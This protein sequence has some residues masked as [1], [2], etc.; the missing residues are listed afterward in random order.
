LPCGEQKRQDESH[1]PLENGLDV[2]S[3][4]REKATGWQVCS[5][6]FEIALVLVRLDHVA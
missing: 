1:E 4:V 3:S 2:T 6:L 5:P